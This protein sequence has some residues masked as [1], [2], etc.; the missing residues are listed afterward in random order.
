M[1][2]IQHFQQRQSEPVC[3]DLIQMIRDGMIRGLKRFV[4]EP[5]DDGI[6]WGI[7]TVAVALPNADEG[8]QF[9]VVIV[10]LHEDDQ[11]AMSFALSVFDALKAVGRASSEDVSQWRRSLFTL[12]PDY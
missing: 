6:T 8:N 1:T 3:T 9:P 10:D 5:Y 12:V 11:A 4:V 2:A 7:Q